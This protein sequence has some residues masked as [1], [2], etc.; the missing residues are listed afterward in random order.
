MIKSN[1]L[2]I[3]MM[4]VFVIFAFVT[5]ISQS[6]NLTE[7]DGNINIKKIN[8]VEYNYLYYLIP[9][10]Y[11]SI[12]TYGEPPELKTEIQRQNW[13]DN[14]KRLAKSLE[15]ELSLNYMYPNGKVITYGENSN[16]Y[17]VVVFYKNLTIE[18]PLIDEVHA[19]IDEKAKTIGIQK[20]PVEFGRGGFPVVGVDWRSES[21]KKADEK[22]ERS[23]RASYKPVVIA[24]YGKLP[25]L[26]TE[27]QRWNWFNKDQRMI[28]EGLRN[29]TLSYFTP[30]GPLV[31]F[32]TDSDG[33]FVATIYKNLTVEKPLLDEIYG[34]ID[35]EAK[36]RGIRDVPVK[37]VLGDFA[38][39][40]LQDVEALNKSAPDSG[41]PGVLITLF[42]GWL[43][44]R[45]R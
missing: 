36:K 3:G 40:D 45:Q 38:R 4:G 11:E 5:N 28:M 10:A 18:K 1:H 41:L 7:G 34:I 16:G 30:K 29:K 26:K 27:D 2:I 21:E 12:A 32:G 24:T 25:E 6:G 44:I 20:V 13:S 42:I 9:T 17:F 39:P 14:L 8:N 37:F 22:Y 19:F 35:E 23:G 31:A 33:Y 15:I 43:F